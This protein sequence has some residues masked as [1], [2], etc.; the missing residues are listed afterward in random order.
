MTRDASDAFDKVREACEGESTAS[1][2]ALAMSILT[3]A[4][5]TSFKDQDDVNLTIDWIA[6][7]L[8]TNTKDA[9]EIVSA[10]RH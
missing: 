2:M 8:K 7:E 5:A 3:E 10:T 4:L 9:R 6:D 1:V